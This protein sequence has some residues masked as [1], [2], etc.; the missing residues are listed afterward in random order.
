V[1]LIKRYLNS[2]DPAAP[3]W[4]IEGCEEALSSIVDRY[5][6]NGLSV[7]EAFNKLIDRKRGFG[8]RIVTWA[9]AGA[10]VVIYV[11]S[12]LDV[13]TQWMPANPDPV[14]VN[15]DGVDDATLVINFD[16]RPRY[17]EL[18]VRGGPVSVCGTW[19]VE[20]GNLEAGWSPELEAEYVADTDENR[21]AARYSDVYSRIR[22]PADWDG[23]LLDGPALPLVLADCSLDWTAMAPLFIHA[24]RFAPIIPYPEADQEA[25]AEGVEWRN[26]AALIPVDDVWNFI[27]KI[28]TGE[29]AEGTPA[30][31]RPND[32]ELGVIVKS[33]VNHIL[34]GADWAGD[35]DIDPEYSYLDL[36]LTAM[37]ETDQELHVTLMLPSPAL[38]ELVRR[39]VIELPD[40]VMWIVLPGTAYDIQDGALL[41]EVELR[42]VR[43]DR[44]MLYMAADFAQLWFGR[45][46]ASV[47]LEVQ[48]VIPVHPVGTMIAG[49]VGH[50][51]CPVGTAVT[52]RRW[53]FTRN[54]MTVQTN[55]E[56]MDA[57]LSG[58]MR[59]PARELGPAPMVGT[60]EYYATRPP[61]VGTADYYAGRRPSEGTADWW[62]SRGL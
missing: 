50:T 36:A 40:A 22:V 53:D 15:M 20:V 41:E 8:W 26:M 48:N 56:E 13:A 47:T 2:A 44:A 18:V 38:G 49:F 54:R 55:Y 30:H 12:L 62:A 34:A 11:Y 43:D 51:M 6:L 17:H 7:F 37:L 42:V 27:E 60:A 45:P 46:R 14:L 61:M 33:R 59:A 28:G 25:G 32:S 31:V 39:K 4:Y 35:S 10:P 23:N 57:T 52:R 16:N 29:N 24:R 3:V 5:A 21:S 9:E 58:Q 19:D 1:Y